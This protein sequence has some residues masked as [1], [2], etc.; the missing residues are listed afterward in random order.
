MLE[1]DNQSGNATLDRPQRHRSSPGQGVRERR[2]S[3]IPSSL[4][5]ATTEEPRAQRPSTLEFLLGTFARV[6]RVGPGFYVFAQRVADTAPPE[7]T[8]VS[9]TSGTRADESPREMSCI[10]GGPC[11][12]RCAVARLHAAQRI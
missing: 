12:H 5:D 3:Q 7:E 8:P 6:V 1:R 2:P 11:T 4:R 10:Y 9:E